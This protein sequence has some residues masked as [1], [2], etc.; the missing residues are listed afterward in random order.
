[1]CQLAETRLAHAATH[2]VC[3]ANASNKLLFW[4]KLSTIEVFPPFIAF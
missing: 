4:I 3:S 2:P 1:M